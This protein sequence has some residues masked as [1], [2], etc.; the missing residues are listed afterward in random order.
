MGRVRKKKKMESNDKCKLWDI[1]AGA[2]VPR[3]VDRLTLCSMQLL[4]R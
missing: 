3:I 2:S 4:L 1:R